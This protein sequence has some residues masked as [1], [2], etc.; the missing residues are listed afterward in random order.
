[1]LYGCNSKEIDNQH[2]EKETNELQK[3][4]DLNLKLYIDDKQ[5]PVIWED[6]QSVRTIFI[7]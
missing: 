2:I 6:N 5:V 1:M 7:I 3:E 4:E